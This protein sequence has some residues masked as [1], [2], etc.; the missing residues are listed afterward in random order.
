MADCAA[1]C[2]ARLEYHS[3]DK[4]AM[5]KTLQ[6][7]IPRDDDY[8]ER[9]Y[10]TTIL[11]KVLN[12]EIYDNLPHAFHEEKN[13]A[14]EY[15]PLRTRRPSVRYG[16]CKLVVDDSVS[17]LFSEGHFPDVDC[18]PDTA[19]AGLAR[20]IKETR[21]NERMIDAATRGSV[22]SVAILM[23]VLAGRV[24]FDVMDTHYLTPIWKATAPDVLEKVVQRYKVKGKAL[25]ALG[26]LAEKDEEDYW[27]QRDWN[28]T[29]EVV[30]IPLSVADAK[31]GK[32]PEVDKA[33]T[34]THS[35][36]FLPM[37][38]VKNLPG[39]DEIDGAQTF[40][41]EA[42]ETSIEIDYQL[43][44]AGRGLK[45][46]SDPTLLIK[47]PAFSD[48]TLVRSASNAIT[49]SAQ[50]DAKLLEINGTAV[51]AV[52]EYVKG[53]RELALETMHGNRS[54]ADKVSAAQSGRAMELMHAALINLADRLRISYGEGALQELLT[55]VCKASEKIALVYKDGSKVGELKLEAPLALR[56]PA[57]F[58]P[59][60]TDRMDEATTLKTLV[61]AGIISRQTAT[62]IIAA[63]Y[64]IEDVEAERLLVD[65]E[66]DAEAPEEPDKPAAKAEE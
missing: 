29:Q 6:A 49:V 36:G 26:Y 44:Q 62:R 42:I 13:P 59:T 22:G 58:A 20:I 7:T 31:T 35:L 24:F 11:S 8:P 45:Y 5:F 66:R 63:D 60:S 40:P 52:M 23:R 1:Y 17:L 16:L 37:V 48:G 34:V 46:S 3:H 51:E 14:G 28:E 55:M 2:C 56:W 12:G 50:G 53:L 41:D 21:L 54:N 4:V 61:E 33:R 27:F 32:Q 47:E 64:D 25:K 43:S 10:R 30:Y 19:R 18:K 38:W 39:G 9:Q 65:G 15:I 57:W